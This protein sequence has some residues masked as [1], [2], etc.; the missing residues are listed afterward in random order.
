MV[1]ACLTYTAHSQYIYY[2]VSN[3][4]QDLQQ[5]FTYTDNKTILAPHTQHCLQN[6]VICL[7]KRTMSKLSSA[8]YTF[9]NLSPVTFG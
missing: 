4:G 7:L 6:S 9:N 2:I 1:N 5:I 3:V 8:Q